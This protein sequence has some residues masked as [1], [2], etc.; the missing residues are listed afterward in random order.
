[1]LKKSSF[2]YFE[3]IGTSSHNIVSTFQKPIHKIVKNNIR[4]YRRKA[5][6]ATRE[7]SLLRGFMD[8]FALLELRIIYTTPAEMVRVPLV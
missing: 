6:R 1:M 2:L 3:S 4:V 5:A 7:G 8:Y